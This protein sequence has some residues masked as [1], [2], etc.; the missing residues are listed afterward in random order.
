M[1][2]NSWL[3]VEPLRDANGKAIPLD[4]EILYTTSG[5]VFQVGQFRYSVRANRWF[6]YGHYEHQRKSWID[7]ASCFLLTPPDSWEKLEED[8]KVKACDYA[9]APRDEY[10][11]FVC[12]ECRFRESESC[13]QAMVIDM[14]A[15]AKK[16]AGIEGEQR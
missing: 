16:L 15:R 9:H 1:G 2:S 14:I 7:I 12:C 8:A 4:T 6:V 10:G 13:Q 11:G 5:Q 3:G